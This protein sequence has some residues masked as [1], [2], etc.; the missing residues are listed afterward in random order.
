MKNPD[1]RKD[2]RKERRIREQRQIKELE[3]RVYAFVLCQ[4]I[5]V[6]R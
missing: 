6:E 5:D 3:E 1:R 4:H 2:A